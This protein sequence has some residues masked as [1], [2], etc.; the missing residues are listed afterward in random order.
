MKLAILSKDGFF[1]ALQF[2]IVTRKELMQFQETW[3]V[4]GAVVVAMDDLTL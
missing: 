1:N 3:L 2:D 4:S